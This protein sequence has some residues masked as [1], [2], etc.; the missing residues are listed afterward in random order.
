MKVVIE[1]DCSGLVFGGNP[2]LEVGRMLVKYGKRLMDYKTYDVR[3]EVG[4][5]IELY[6]ANGSKVGSLK[7]M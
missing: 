4:D 2:A 3:L 6:D 7:V 1:I 5:D